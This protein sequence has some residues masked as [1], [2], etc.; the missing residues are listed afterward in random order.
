MAEPT[1]TAPAQK[2]GLAAAGAQAL[3]LWKKLS[4]GKRL[5]IVMT[6]IGVFAGVLFLSLRPDGHA[7][8]PL[9]EKLTPED[10]V[11]LTTALD[12]HGI[13]HR[14]ADDGATIEVPP[15]RAGEARVV[16]AA[17]GLPHTGAGFELFDHEQLGQSSF[18]EQVN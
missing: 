14:F 1:P 7:R 15:E 2:P 6:A 12:G 4:R 3:T 16:A 9:V 5:A 18:A 10:A 11:E 17:A 13:P 8:A